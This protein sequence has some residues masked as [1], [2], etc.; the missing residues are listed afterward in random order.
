MFSGLCA[1]AVAQQVSLALLQPES[2]EASPMVK[3]A[4]P[5]TLPEAPSHRF[6]DRKNT[7]L[8]AT[9]AAFSTADFVVTRNN[10]RNGGQELNPVTR[11]FAGSTAGLAVNFAG[12]AAGVVAVS[13]LFHKTG[14]HKL[15]RA[16]SLVNIGSSAGAVM[17]DLRH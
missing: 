8:F 1:S 15:E 17:F 6:W 11:V 7:I 12:E 4:E 5:M 9:S 14:H 10:L 16:V 13:Y 2:I 3:S